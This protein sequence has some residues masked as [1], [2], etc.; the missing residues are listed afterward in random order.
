MRIIR[1]L[2]AGQVRGPPSGNTPAT[3][4]GPGIGLARSHR[5]SPA[6]SRWP[7]RRGCRGPPS[8]C[9]RAAT[10]ACAPLPS[11][12]L[13]GRF[14]QQPV[15]APRAWPKSAFSRPGAPR[16]GRRASA[17][18]GN[19]QGVPTTTFRCDTRVEP[20]PD[21]VWAVLTDV[22]LI[23]QWFPAVREALRRRAPPLDH[24]RGNAEVPRDGVTGAAA[25][26]RL[27][28]GA[29]SND[30]DKIMNQQSSSCLP[31]VN[32]QAVWVSCRHER[33]ESGTGLGLAASRGPRRPS[34]TRS[35]PGCVE[36]PRRCTRRRRRR[37]APAGR[38]N[39]RCDRVVRLPLLG[40]HGP[41]RLHRC[42]SRRG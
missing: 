37:G 6:V 38:T 28:T 9:G 17:T 20:D 18:R 25:G 26:T 34:A 27:F 15:T 1:A 29:P 32:V 19:A 31:C 7:P 5:P 10:A 42:H 23:P 4:P 39:G 33:S 22:C 35:R 36:C 30:P 3:A 14:G 41:Q 8:S 16:A 13:V 21:R 24:T 12:A 11:K 2:D 40:R